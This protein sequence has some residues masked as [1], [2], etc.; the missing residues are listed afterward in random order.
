[1]KDTE[2]F[3]Q[4]DIHKN[5]LEPKAMTNHLLHESCITENCITPI[6]EQNVLDICK[7]IYTP[8]DCKQITT[9]C[10]TV[11]IPFTRGCANQMIEGSVSC[12]EVYQEMNKYT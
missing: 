8:E 12:L 10:N 7:K 2:Y 6:N 11:C 5:N 3:R 9:T 1:M 4:I